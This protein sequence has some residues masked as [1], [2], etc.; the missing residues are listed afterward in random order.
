MSFYYDALDIN[1]KSVKGAVS[2]K[3]NLIIKVKSDN[4][5]CNFILCDYT[6]T[7]IKTYK[8][9]KC[10]NG[11]NLEL[12]SLENGIYYYYFNSSNKN[13]YKDDNYKSTNIGK[14]YFQLTV[15]DSNYI[16][17][18]D[19]KGGIFYQIFPDRF[20]RVED[21]KKLKPLRVWGE[22]PYYK[23]NE[24]GKILNN[25]FFGG[26]FKGIIKKLDY[27]KSLGVSIIYLNP[28]TKAYSNHRYD[29][30]NYFEIDE[31][32]GTEKDFKRLIDSAHKKGIKIILDGVYNH[33]G[34]DSIYF[35]KYGNYDSLGAYQ[36]KESKYYSWYNFKNYPSEYSSWWGIDILPQINK[37][38]LSF[39]DYIS[40][41]N[42]VIDHYMKMGVDGFRLDVVD[43]LPIIF[44]KKIRK[45]IKKVNKNGLV[46]GEVWEDATNKIAYEENKE[47]FC[48]DRLD[49]VMNYPLK[50]GIIN[51]LLSKDA[52]CL[53]KTVSEQ[54]N[55]YPKFS[56]D[57]L[58]NIL[59]T[60]DTARILT[61]LGGDDI[62]LNREES[63]KY[64]L[65]K[66]KLDLA[67][68]RLEI[69]VILL[70][71]IYG[72]PC[73]Y[74]GDERGTE[75]L[76]D[77][78]NRTC[79]DW[80]KRSKITNFYKKLGKIRREN[81][82]FSGGETKILYSNGGLFS[83]ERTLN[84]KKVIVI[85]NVSEYVYEIKGDNEFY[86]L[87]NKKTKKKFTIKKDGWLVLQP[88]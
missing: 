7:Y 10:E 11:F 88:K 22:M 5:D 3:E 71:T 27:L 52:S 32:L 53:T 39:Q 21:N 33:T 74:Y 76:K 70:Y 42:G 38:N 49:S 14:D 15:Y 69:A 13:Y 24:K 83:F 40:S 64:T 29:T 80:S 75:G 28:I 19:L 37:D 79:I 68:K 41:K 67:Y 35:N 20:C 55:N 34:D 18:N 47:Y 2:N 65:S 77:P 62:N 25:D 56:L 73:I 4:L 85:T 1:F 26:N 63:A 82:V 45:A 8:M 46:L 66:D 87:Y 60:H 57:I 86:D 17:P 54:L 78:F 23:P 59:G 50:D 51:Y 43:E 48:G 9:Q 72:N 6:K 12:N 61:V 16:V 44:L 31:L 30:A 81:E 36:S 84:D 58:M